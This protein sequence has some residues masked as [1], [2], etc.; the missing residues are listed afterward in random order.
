[1]SVSLRR[2]RAAV[3]V[4]V[5]GEVDMVTAPAVREAVD[6]A[7]RDP[8]VAVVVIDLSDVDY[9]GSAGLQTLLWAHNTV[10]AHHGLTLRVVVDHTRAVIRPLQITG[11]DRELPLLCYL[12]QAL[13]VDPTSEG[14]L[15]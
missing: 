6:E 7:R 10:L 5:T 8:G 14:T 11:L 15:H 13:E 9:F 1:M 2:V 4:T 12:E 3:V